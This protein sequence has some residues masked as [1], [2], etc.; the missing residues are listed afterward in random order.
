MLTKNPLG[1]ILS[2]KCRRCGGCSLRLLRT[3][4]HDNGVGLQCT[5]NWWA[6]TCL[7][8]RPT[9]RICTLFL[10]ARYVCIWLSKIGGCILNEFSLTS[11]EHTAIFYVMP[12]FP[13]LAVVMMAN[14]HITTCVVS[15]KPCLVG[16]LLCVPYLHSVYRWFGRSFRFPFCLIL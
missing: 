16:K 1:F 14:A 12:D 11:N 9:N 3:A 2:T 8:H 13:T 15:R 7:I 6:C 5:T 4:W 10:C